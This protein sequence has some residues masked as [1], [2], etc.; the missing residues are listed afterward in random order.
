MTM[1]G[2]FKRLSMLQ[3]ELDLSNHQMVICSVQ[4]NLRKDILKYKTKPVNY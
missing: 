2:K 4:C 1:G 3:M